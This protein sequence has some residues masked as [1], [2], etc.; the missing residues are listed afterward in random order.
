MSSQV[1]LTLA[2]PDG[3][4]P[5]PNRLAWSADSAIQSRSLW[6]PNTE[7]PT[8]ANPVEQLLGL[9][10]TALTGEDQQGMDVATEP[11]PGGH[12]PTETTY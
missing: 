11:A 10:V 1:P 6:T 3:A 12:I 7:I 4:P 2:R 9:A 5:S 8:E